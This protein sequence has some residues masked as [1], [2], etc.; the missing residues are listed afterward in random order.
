MRSW[1]PLAL[2]A[3]ACGAPPPVDTDTVDTDAADTDAID[4]DPPV[5]AVILSAPTV[6]ASDTTGAPVPLDAVDARHRLTC[7]AGVEPADTPLTLAWRRADGT[8]LGEGPTLRA[9]A[10][11]KGDLVRCL[12]TAAPAGL[13]P[14]E[15]ASADVA[16]GDA[17]PDPGPA[18]IVATEGADPADPTVRATLACA[19]DAPVD[20]DAR[21]TPTRTGTLWRVDG[22]EVTDTGDT[23]AAPAFA[24]GQAVTC[25]VTFD[26]AGV[27]VA[28]E[29]PAVSIGN[30]PPRLTGPTLPATIR[31]NDVVTA[32]FS[33]DDPDDAAPA[34]TWAWIRNSSPL[35]VASD[36][37]DGSNPTAG[38]SRDDAL[39]VE[40]SVDDGQGGTA[41]GAAGPVV[42][43][44]TP[45]VLTATVLGPPLGASSLVSVSASAV[46]ADADAVV[47]STLWRVNG[48]IVPVA[49][50]ALSLSGGTHFTE[51]DTVAVTVTA[52]DARQDSDAQTFGPY[53][54]GP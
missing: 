35:A 36:T 50:D 4:T 16:I 22:V 7:A 11:A 1:T 31:T 48:A 34:V 47:I 9:P 20:P 53:L 27:S 49:P 10:F 12:A 8:P 17:P 38:F 30:A 26:S 41:F 39:E 24:R 18:R 5:P 40:L 32:V 13:A 25:T 23:L 45:P 2:L 46:D 52:I 33:I 43:D 19:A 28:S 3:A 6:S 15:A 29:A 21:D 44:N 14:V 54:V 42:V 37:I 51:G